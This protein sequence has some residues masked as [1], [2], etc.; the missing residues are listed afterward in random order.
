MGG[1]A[2]QEESEQQV[3]QVFFRETGAWRFPARLPGDISGLGR[4]AVSSALF[5]PEIFFLAPTL[6]SVMILG[7]GT[8][9]T[10]YKE[11]ALQWSGHM[12]KPSSGAVL[13][14]GWGRKPS[15]ASSLCPAQP[16]HLGA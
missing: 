11:F 5:N 10:G 13:L 6:C 15:S 1:R 4:W 8:L 7:N 14:P 3:S 12:K 2:G 9:L 16:G